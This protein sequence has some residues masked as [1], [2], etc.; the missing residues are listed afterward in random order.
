MASTYEPIATYTVSGSAAANY[1]FTS[2]PQTFTDLV[3]VTSVIYTNSS[4]SIFYRLNGDTNNNYSTIALD[5]S[6]SPVVPYQS[7]TSVSFLYG[8]I[9]STTSSPNTS[10]TSFNN[11]SNTTTY[12][13]SLGK[14]AYGNAGIYVGLWRSTAAITSIYLEPVSTTFAVGSTFTLYGIKAA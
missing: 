9:G 4:P 5:G 8:F 1:T 13:T 3:L 6:S 12:K 7:N 2:I 14:A 11:Y 10:V